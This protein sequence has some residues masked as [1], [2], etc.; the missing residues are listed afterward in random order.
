MLKFNLLARTSH[1]TAAMRF[2]SMTLAVALAYKRL[3]TAV[4]GALPLATHARLARLADR[5]ADGATHR[6]LG[7]TASRPAS[8]ANG[9]ANGLASRLA[10]RL[11]NGLANRLANRLAFVETSV[12]TTGSLATHTFLG[13]HATSVCIMTPFVL[14]TKSGTTG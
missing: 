11:A 2:A 14:P 10:S 5:L 12:S 9:L 13:A 6:A 4:F 1:R 3:A 8:L 7:R